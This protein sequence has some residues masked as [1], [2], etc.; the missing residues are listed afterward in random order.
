MDENRKMLDVRI[1]EA[2]ELFQASLEKI[3]VPYN[4]N[5]EEM[6]RNI[7]QLKEVVKDVLRF[8]KALGDKLATKLNNTIDAVTFQKTIENLNESFSQTYLLNTQK[9]KELNDKEY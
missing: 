5:F 6:D 7:T 1:V 2:E 3:I 9:I 4:Q 8:T